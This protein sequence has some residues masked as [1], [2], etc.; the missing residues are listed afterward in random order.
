[1][2]EQLRA[3]T[4]RGGSPPT[5][6]VLFNFN[7]AEE[8]ILQAAHGFVQHEWFRQ[9]RMFINM[10]SVGSGGRQLVF[11]M[12]PGHAWISEAYAAS[13]PR[14]HGSVVG[15]DIFESGIIPSDTDFRIYRDFGRVPG[16]DLAV[17]QNGYVYHTRQDVPS[18]IQPGTLQFGGDNMLALVRHLATTDALQYDETAARHQ[19]VYFDF[20]ETV[21]VECSLTTLLA[22]NVVALAGA[23]LLLRRWATPSGVKRGARDL[24]L[25]LGSAVLAPTLVG[26]GV[27]CLGVQ[28]TWYSSP[29]LFVGLFLVPATIGITFSTVLSKRSDCSEQ[30]METDTFV[31]SALFWMALLGVSTAARLGSSY[32]FL[33]WVAFPVAARA[34]AEALWGSAASRQ[35]SVK[36]MVFQ[37]VAGQAVPLILTFTV[38]FPI[39]DIFMPLMGRCGTD[40]PADAVIGGLVGLACFLLAVSPRSHLHACRLTAALPWKLAAATVAVAVVVALNTRPYSVLRPKRLYVQHTVRLVHSLQ[41]RTP[42]HDSGLWVNSLDGNDLLTVAPDIPM[43]VGAEEQVLQDGVYGGFPWL[44]PVKMAVSRSLYRRDTPAYALPGRPGDASRPEGSAHI[45]D[46]P[47]T[48]SLRLENKTRLW[49]RDGRRAVRLSFSASGPD[50]STLYLQ[51]CQH[52]NRGTTI[53]SWSLT[54]EPPTVNQ[55]R[56]LFVYL[57]S[58]TPAVDLPSLWL[59]YEESVDR[60]PECDASLGIALAGHHL[61]TTTEEIRAVEKEL[62]EWVD[63]IGWVSTYES[64]LF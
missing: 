58:G 7:G 60:P 45:I 36:R 64:W 24:L 53:T 25:C 46:A 57:A 13:V 8:N 55:V 6:A 40:V 23:S 50:H 1:M 2:L 44:Y 9:V 5:N 10:E 54:D 4:S 63:M 15:Q 12:G 3:L 47:H 27:M 16:I 52:A 41:G 28:L 35:H 43:L 38:T 42:Q 48:A 29:W 39:F 34:A 17:V 21:M 33:A 32:I 19:P 49:E 37:L 30:Q 31:A 26:L 59:E 18:A 20:F 62:P 51:P 14:P 56:R 61:T 22:A 11:Q